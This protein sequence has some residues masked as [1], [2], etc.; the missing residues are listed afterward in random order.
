MDFEI[1]TNKYNI[2]ASGSFILS[3]GYV[4]FKIETL[5]FRLSFDND[6]SREEHHIQG[7]LKEDM[8]GKYFD[9]S[10]FNYDSMFD[11]PSKPLKVG[12]LNGFPLYF[13]FS[14]STL[15]GNNSHKSRIIVYTWY[16]SKKHENGNSDEVE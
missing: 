1:S 8:Y 11:T 5:R 7:N 3:E 13:S 2:I 9:L 15:S 16:T 10:V 4:E 14:V 12:I 6:E